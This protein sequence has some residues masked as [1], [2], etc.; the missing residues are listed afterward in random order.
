MYSTEANSRA[1]VRIFGDPSCFSRRLLAL[2]FGAVADSSACG[3]AGAPL[4]G[5]GSEQPLRGRERERRD[6]E[7]LRL[8]CRKDIPVSA[9]VFLRCIL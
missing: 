4:A 2:V 7:L 6:C 5:G 1:S 8:P 9:S 3:C